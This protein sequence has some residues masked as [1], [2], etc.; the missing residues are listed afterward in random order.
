LT[1]VDGPLAEAVSKAA[2]DAAKAI[3]A[4]PGEPLAPAHTDWLRNLL[5]V[6][7]P[8][9]EV[10]RFRAAAR[11]TGGVPWHLDLDHEEARLL[12]PMAGQGPEARALA[13]ELRE[14]IA[15]RHHRVLARWHEAGTCPLDLHRLIPIPDTILTLGE[16]APTARR[17]LWSHWGTTQP[18]RQVR[19]R[20]EN[21]DR[22]LRRSARVVYEFLSADWTP[23]QALLRLRR[24]WPTLVLAV[25]PCYGEANGAGDA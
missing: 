19:V 11:G 4:G 23:W 13:R 14:V 3:S 21:G 9:G 24:D 2:D 1:L 22:R 17:W 16:D 12:A 6:S 20:E 7:G 5:T 25:D 10:A 15:A 8:A 18:L